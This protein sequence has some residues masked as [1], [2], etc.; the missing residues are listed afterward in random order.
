[1]HSLEL[2]PSRCAICTTEG[3]ATELYPANF[4]SGAFT[5]AVFSARRMPDRLRY[6]M[7][8]CA[9]CGLVRSDPV[10]EPEALARLYARSAF[11]YTSEVDNIK[12]TYGRC[13]ARLETYGARKG[14][15]L[16]IGCGNGFF[17]EEALDR[18][19]SVVK[20]VEPSEDAVSKADPRIRPHIARSA[21]RP[22]LFGSQR[23]DVICMFQLIDHVPDPGA[24]VSECGSLLN[25]GGFIL[26]ISHN[27]DAL[28]SR[29]L[30]SRSPI[31][32]IEHTFLFS[33]CTVSRLFSARGF[34]VLKVGPVFNRYSA[35]YLLRLS[36]LPRALKRALLRAIENN[37]AGRIRFLIPLGNFYC[38]AQK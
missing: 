8:R 18:G 35:S 28:S 3:N 24:L 1:M 2:R 26:C 31:V 32:D 6:R 30:K 10:A 4:D 19:Y 11:D 37:F 13:L 22:G 14:S 17:L 7:V 20:G 34:S 29:I 27:I 36:P 5:P 23:F 33:P 9:E 16:E 15:L 12:A 38:I 21:M 25:P